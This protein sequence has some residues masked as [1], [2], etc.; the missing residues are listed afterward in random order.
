MFNYILLASFCSTTLEPI[1]AFLNAILCVCMCAHICILFICPYMQPVSALF[2]QRGKYET[3]LRRLQKHM[4]C[5]L[6]HG[7]QWYPSCSSHNCKQISQFSPTQTRMW[8]LLVDIS[9]DFRTVFS[10]AF[11]RHMYEWLFPSYSFIFTFSSL[12]A[13]CLLP[14]LFLFSLGMNFATLYFWSLFRNFSFSLIFHWSLP[15]LFCLSSPLQ[16]E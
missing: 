14:L 6:S 10:M 12:L 3:H 7:Y 1:Q 2:S 8:C 13:F 5:P 15:F 16:R 9:D 4:C 11:S